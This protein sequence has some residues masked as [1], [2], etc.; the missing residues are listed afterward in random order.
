MK[1]V[2]RFVQVWGLLGVVSLLIYVGLILLG[3]GLPKRPTILLGLLA[4]SLAAAILLVGD[5]Q[6][7]STKIPPDGLSFAGLIYLLLSSRRSLLTLIVL[8]LV[9]SGVCSYYLVSSLFRVERS[10]GGLVISLPEQTMTFL[11]IHAE[12]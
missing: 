10:P 3:F 1:T 6:T 5:E 8:V 11:P 12:G 2:V 4:V 9:G 7:A